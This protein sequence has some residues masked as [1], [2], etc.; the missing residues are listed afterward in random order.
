MI[1]ELLNL[2]FPTNSESSRNLSPKLQLRRA[3]NSLILFFQVKMSKTHSPTIFNGEADNF[4][5]PNFTLEINKRMTV[6]KSIRVNGDYGDDD[7]PGTGWN[8]A[9]PNEKFEMNVPDRILVVGKFLRSEKAVDLTGFFLATF[10]KLPVY[11]R[12]NS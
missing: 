12:S 7:L 4:Y 1:F 5:D 8:Q 2:V 11:F 3:R 9:I 10:H 6:P